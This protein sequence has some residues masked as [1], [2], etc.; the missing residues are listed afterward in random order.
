[1]EGE[2]PF[3][4]V[5]DLDNGNLLNNWALGQ[6]HEDEEEEQEEEDEDEEEEEEED[7][8]EDWNDGSQNILCWGLNCFASKDIM[9]GEELLG[10]YGDF[11]SHYSWTSMG[12]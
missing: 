7:K 9:K 12:L 4:S 1:M 10:N 8:E 11:V 2:I 5:V 3:A 6:Y